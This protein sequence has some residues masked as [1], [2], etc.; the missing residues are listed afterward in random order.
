MNSC[1]CRCVWVWACVRVHVGV[2]ERKYKCV[3]YQ[4]HARKCEERYLATKQT[5]VYQVSQNQEKGTCEYLHI[6]NTSIPT[7][8][9]TYNAIIIL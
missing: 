9:H 2:T 8:I 6:N 1:V 4:N 7:Y 3:F 5:Q